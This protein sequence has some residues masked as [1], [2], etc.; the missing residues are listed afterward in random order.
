MSVEY[1]GEYRVLN[2]VNTGQSSRLLHGYNDRTREVVCIKTL[3]D[4]SA[5]DKEQIKI[6]K[7]EYEVASG[8][9]HP[10][11]IRVFSYG[12]RGEVPYIVM[13]WFSAPNVKLLISRGYG[14]YCDHI[15]RIML[16]MVE[17]L[18]YLHLRGWVHRDVK[19]DNFLFDVGAGELRLIDFAIARRS[20][21]G[22]RR[23]F[24]GR[25]QP[26]GTVSY[27][28]PEQI[29][30]L[31]PETGSDVYSLG[32]VFYELLT[33]RTPFSGDSA[34]DLLRKHIATP[35]PNV[36]AKNKNITKDF[37]DLLKTMMAKSAKDRPKNATELLKIMQKIKVFQTNPK[38]ENIG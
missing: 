9:S 1:F 4:R 21:A 8:L 37:S 35:P 14:Q 15:V 16:S 11:L 3:L 32:C 17:S 24:A 22:I 27:M 33:M 25:L 36:M 23:L 7:W 38:P 10:K 29:K 20:V 30:G 26:Q 31:P 6:L 13:E 19:P 34:N 5:R 12:W 2:L 18:S 28:A